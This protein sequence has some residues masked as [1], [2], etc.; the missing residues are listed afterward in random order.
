MQVDRADEKAFAQAGVVLAPRAGSNK[1]ILFG[2][3]H[4][5]LSVVVITANLQKICILRS[6]LLS[7]KQIDWPDLPASNARAMG[8]NVARL[9]IVQNKFV[10]RDQNGTQVP[11]GGDDDPVSRIRMKSSWQPRA[12]H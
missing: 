4:T 10:L 6:Q 3:V 9:A 2:L 1:V 5:G 8:F 12:G 11:C 7:L